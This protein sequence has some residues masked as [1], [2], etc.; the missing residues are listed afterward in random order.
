ML[1]KCYILENAYDLSEKT[2]N[3]NDE[4]SP[5]YVLLENLYCGICGSDYSCFIGRRGKYPLSLG[6]EF[7]SRVIQTSSGVSN[8]AIGDI[9]VSDLNYRCGNCYYCKDSKSHLCIENNIEDFSNRAFAQFTLINSKYLFP[10]N[11]STITI[12]ATLIEPL[13]CI[14]HAAATLDLKSDDSIVIVGGGSLGT[15]FCFY[16]KI[17]LGIQDVTICEKIDARRTFLV[18]TFNAKELKSMEAKQLKIIECTNSIE[19]IQFALNIAC[20]NA[21]ICFMSHL[22]GVD[23]PKIYDMLCSKEIDAS[24]PLRNGGVENLILAQRYICEYWKQEFCRCFAVY[25]L[26]D[27]QKAFTDKPTSPYNKQ[28]IKIQA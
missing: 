7:V 26:S 14:L 24:F 27:L 15:L 10:I 18:E 3:V 4:L 17:I 23:T 20:Q 12:A 5:G 2:T 8:L 25:D 9:V 28:I 1:N 13:S 16:L 19:G 22:Y 6:H 11:P 21:K